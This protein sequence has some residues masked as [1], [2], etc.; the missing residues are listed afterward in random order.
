MIKNITFIFLL[1][2][3]CLVLQAQHDSLNL[4]TNRQQ[5]VLKLYV[6]TGVNQ[7]TYYGALNQKTYHFLINNNIGYSGE[8]GVSYMKNMIGLNY[9]T[10][11]FSESKNS[12]ADH[13]NFLSRYNKYGMMLSHKIPI[14]DYL[15][16]VPGVGFSFWQTIV[17]TD[18]LDAEGKPYFYWNDGTIRAV[19]ETYQNTLVN[20][21]VLKRDYVFETVLGS[22]SYFSIPLQA[23]IHVDLNQNISMFLGIRFNYIFAKNIDYSSSTKSDFI[24]AGYFGVSYVFIRK[25]NLDKMSKEQSIF[26]KQLIMQD[27]DGDGVPDFEDKC[28]TIGKAGKVDK[29]GCPMDSDGDGI[30]DERDFEKNSKHPHLT[31]I[32]G[33]EVAVPS[34]KELKQE[35]MEEDALD[36]KRN[37]GDFEKEINLREDKYDMDYQKNHQPVIINLNDKEVQKTWGDMY[38]SASPRP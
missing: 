25:P 11:S 32:N 36:S 35:K 33:I 2:S 38:N 31:D 15:S 4:T 28:P 5:K 12:V 19:S 30:P 24:L 37:E 6:G 22:K 14:S 27:T 34:A 29:S 16:F 13:R 20:P 17:R 23:A 10:G 1:F 8:V 9:E 18:T 26:Y 21:S 7:N 3:T